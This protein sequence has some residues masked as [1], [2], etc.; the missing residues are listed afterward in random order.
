MNTPTVKADVTR[1]PQSH[2]PDFRNNPCYLARNTAR[3]QVSFYS[4]PQKKER[5]KASQVLDCVAKGVTVSSRPKPI[6]PL[7]MAMRRVSAQGDS[8]RTLMSALDRVE[9]ES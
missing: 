3:K 8:H 2:F 1:L 9:K 5:A 6:L 7:A 4:W